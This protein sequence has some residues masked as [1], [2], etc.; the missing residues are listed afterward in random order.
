MIDAKA[1]EATI[2]LLQNFINLLAIIKNAEYNFNVESYSNFRFLLNDFD[3]SFLLF[4]FK[5]TE[6]NF[7]LK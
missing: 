4:F 7:L 6:K 3:N 1:I 5:K 2:N